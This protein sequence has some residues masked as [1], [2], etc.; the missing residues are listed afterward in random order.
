MVSLEFFIDM[1]VLGFDS[2]YNRSEYQKY[3]LGAKA[4]GAYG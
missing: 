2:A 4:A 3:F 1:I